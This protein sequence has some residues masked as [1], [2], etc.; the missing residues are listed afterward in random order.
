V[1]G[2]CGV[3][4]QTHRAV[5]ALVSAACNTALYNAHWASRKPRPSKGGAFS[6]LRAYQQWCSPGTTRSAGRRVGEDRN[7]PQE[8]NGPA[9]RF[10]FVG[11][12]ILEPRKIRR[13]AASR[14]GVGR[15]LCGDTRQHGPDRFSVCRLQEVTIIACCVSQPSGLDSAVA[16]Q[17]NNVGLLY[18]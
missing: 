4:R 1:F 5:W 9:G 18:W 14:A 15:Y 2:K 16:R 12:L 17:R 10:A 6:F 3:A 7:S 13:A 8:L 11:V